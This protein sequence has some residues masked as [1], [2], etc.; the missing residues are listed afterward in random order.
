MSIRFFNVCFY[1]DIDD[2]EKHLMNSKTCILKYP[3][4]DSLSFY[5]IVM[6]PMSKYFHAL[7]EDLDVSSLTEEQQKLYEKAKLS[8]A[9]EVHLGDKTFE[10]NSFDPASYSMLYHFKSK[11]SQ[12]LANG[13]VFKMVEYTNKDIM[14]SVNKSQ[15]AQS[16]FSVIY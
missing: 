2:C 3:K 16:F 1:Y 7:K 10:M 11:T 9:S 4:S 5:Y 6:H 14:Y 12:K 8:K 13:M 15:R